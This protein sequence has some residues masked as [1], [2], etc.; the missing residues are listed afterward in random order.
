MIFRKLRSGLFLFLKFLPLPIHVLLLMHFCSFLIARQ[1]LLSIPCI[2]FLPSVI[3]QARNSH[4]MAETL[5]AYFLSHG[6]GPMPLLNDPS[7]GPIISHWKKLSSS[8]VSPKAILVISAHWEESKPTLTSAERPS[9]L[10][11]YYG[12][13][14]ESYKVCL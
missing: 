1:V 8:I 9:L 5:P 13:P 11:D 3:V 2:Y 7:H 14:P 6:G 4:T 12:F 10:Y